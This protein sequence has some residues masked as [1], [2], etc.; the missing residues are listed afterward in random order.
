MSSILNSPDILA[1]L[2][3]RKSATGRKLKASRQ[4]MMEGASQ[5][6]SPLPKN[7]SRAQNVSRLVS[8][9]ILIYN[10]IRIFARIYSAARSL[11]GRR[12]YRRR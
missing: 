4:H 9:G 12:R 6:W 7:A 3:Q 10:G 8:N 1:D 2:R 5:L 11:F